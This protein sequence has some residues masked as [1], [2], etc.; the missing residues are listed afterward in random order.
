[1]KAVSPHWAAALA[2]LLLAAGA[3]AAELSGEDIVRHC[4]DKYA[5]ADQRSRLIVTLADRDGHVARSEYLRLWKDYQ[6]HHGVTDKVM[7]F[8]QSP[9][10]ARGVNFMRWGYATRTGRPADQ[11]VYLP[12]ISR[13]RRVS[14]RDRNESDWGYSEED[15]R[16]RDPDEDRH[17][18]VEVVLEQGEEYYVVESVPQGKSLY[19]KRVTRY[20]K[21]ADWKDCAPRRVD[22]YDKQGMLVKQQFITWRVLNGAWAWDTAV[23]Y[24]PRDDVTA[25]YQMLDTEVDVGLSE[26]LFSERQLERGYPDFKH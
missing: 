22:Y 26:R 4:D 2:G 11:W 8:T 6:G 25:T 23:M 17:R 16:R 19:G 10:D 14:Q 9:L 13:V 18:L 1:M 15:L 3:G 7:L 5:G 12:E 20:L 21:T 24:N